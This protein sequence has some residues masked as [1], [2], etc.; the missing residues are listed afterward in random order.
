MT[1]PASSRED[2]QFASPSKYTQRF[3]LSIIRIISV[4]TVSIHLE[5]DFRPSPTWDSPRWTRDILWE[6]LLLG[7]CSHN[8]SVI[9]YNRQKIILIKQFQAGIESAWMANI[10]CVLNKNFKIMSSTSTHKGQ[11]YS[12]LKTYQEVKEPA[13]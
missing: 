7:T 8:A 11:F 12:K 3:R 13:N 9:T 1:S 6:K 5:W 10:T 4:S 2:A